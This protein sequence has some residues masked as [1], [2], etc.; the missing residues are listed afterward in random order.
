MNSWHGGM[1]GMGE[2]EFTANV[3]LFQEVGTRRW[4]GWRSGNGRMEGYNAR[5]HA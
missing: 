1:E 5:E 3:A 2:A 4:E